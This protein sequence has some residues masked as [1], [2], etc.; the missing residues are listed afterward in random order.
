MRRT[1]ALLGVGLVLA[2]GAGIAYAATDG[3]SSGSGWVTQRGTFTVPVGEVVGHVLPLTGITVAGECFSGTGFLSARVV[4]QAGSGNTMDLFEGGPRPRGTLG[5]T[6]W[7]V[8]LGTEGVFGIDPLGGNT[9][10]AM[11]KD[12]IAT[13]TV[14]GAADLAAGVCNFLWQALE[15]PTGDSGPPGGVVPV[16][17]S[18][19]TGR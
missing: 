2:L 7:T 3:T 17:P 18:G 19:G 4:F 13:V 9:V 8:S 10:V 15:V 14:G 6:S 11:S 12:A 5:G 16:Q 1:L